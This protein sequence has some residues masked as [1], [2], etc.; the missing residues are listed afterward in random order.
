M[1]KNLL[2]FLK[3]KQDL[4]YKK[5]KFPFFA[6]HGQKK[7]VQFFFVK[8]LSTSSYWTK[9]VKSNQAATTGRRKTPK[10]FLFWC[11]LLFIKKINFKLFKTLKLLSNHKIF[12][13]QEIIKRQISPK[14]KFSSNPNISVAC[15][16][17]KTLTTRHCFGFFSSF[18]DGT[19]SPLTLSQHDTWSLIFIT[20]EKE[21]C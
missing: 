18:G 20:G 17:I 2:Y 3:H 4:Q 9:I 15:P 1:K 21:K 8:F 16:V 14:K 19:F 10:G 6:F 11:L 7:V 12:I 5:W 13:K